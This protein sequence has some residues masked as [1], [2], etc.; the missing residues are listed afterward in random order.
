MRAPFLIAA[1]ALALAGCAK[2]TPPEAA[3][4]P[5]VVR[6]ITMGGIEQVQIYSGEV[7]ARREVDRSFRVGGKVIERKVNLGDTVKQG[8]LLARL[9]PEDVRLSAQ[10]ASAQVSA[11]EADLRLAA[12]EFQRAQSLS[13]RNFVSGS[14]VD[15]RREAVR[16][17]E[18]RLKQARSQ[19]EVASNQ[20]NYASLVAD[21]D[22]VVTLTPVEVGQVVAA[23]QAVVRVAESGERDVLI[24]VPEKRIAS[25]K[26]GDPALVRPWADQEKTLAGSV[27]EVGAAADTATRTYPVRVTVESGDSLPLGATAA[28]GFAGEAQNSVVLPNTALTQRDGKASVWVVAPSGVLQEKPVTVSAFRE[29]G[30]VVSSG[31]ANGDKVVV[32]GAHK[33]VAGMKVRPVAEATPAALDAQ[34]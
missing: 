32:V 9:D 23:G 29:D 7:R 31:L 25:I 33:M 21:R 18:A 19:A 17:A 20:A 16:A 30:A 8:Q 13:E 11:A 15:Q 4:R 2:E 24:Y 3:P 28:V 14:V 5:A 34:R 6:Q 27:R 12:N 26:V 22:G 1:V 10:A